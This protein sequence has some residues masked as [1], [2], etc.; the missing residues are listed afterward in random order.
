MNESGLKFLLVGLGL[1]LGGCSAGH[2]VWALRSHWYE[3][4]SSLYL[5]TKE[6]APENQRKHME[7]MER[8]L[9]ECDARGLKP[10]PGIHAEYALYAARLGRT[11]EVAAHLAREM[12]SYPE[13]AVFIGVLARILGISLPQTAPEGESD[14]GGE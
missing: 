11:G 7:A 5:A 12:E 14:G 3:Y 1:L 9:S 10:P 2:G 6:P 8:L 13:S 4:E